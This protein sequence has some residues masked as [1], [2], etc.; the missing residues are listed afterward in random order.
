[1]SFPSGYPSN[2]PRCQFSTHRHHSP[3]SRRPP[4]RKLGGSVKHHPRGSLQIPSPLLLPLPLPSSGSITAAITRRHSSIRGDLFS[5]SSCHLS[6]ST[7]DSLVLTPSAAS[8]SVSGF[9]HHL[10]ETTHANSSLRPP[11]HSRIPRS[12][13]HASPPP[14][15]L[16]RFPNGTRTR[17][18]PQAGRPY[19]DNTQPQ[20]LCGLF[21]AA[22]RGIIRPQTPKPPNLCHAWV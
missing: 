17:R 7:P 21:P 11:T 5:S 6:G 2:F 12:C 18:K 8:C 15:T 20:I 10:A 19:G 9:R 1:M 22:R 4:Q 16:P 14:P 3:P 13:S